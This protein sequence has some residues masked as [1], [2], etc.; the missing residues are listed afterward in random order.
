MGVRQPFLHQLTGIVAEMMKKPYPELTE[1]VDRVSQVIRG[2]EED[3]FSKI[4][5][6]LQR[7]ERVFSDMESKGIV[8]VPGTDAFDMYQTFG[9]PPELFETLAAERNF[10]FDRQGFEASMEEHGKVSGAGQRVE[11]FK[12]GPLDALK[13]VMHGTKFLGYEVTESPAVVKGIIAQDKLCETLTEVGHAAAVAI[14]LDQSPFYGESGGQVG[15]T[16]ELIGDGIRFEVTDTQ[17]NGEFILHMGHLRQGSLKLGASLTARVDAS[18]R[19]GI[20][21]AHSATHILH[22]ALQKYVGSHALQR[23]SKVDRDWLRFDFTNNGAVDRE[24][25]AKIEAEVNERIIAADSVSWQV[26]P[27]AEARK[28]GAMMLFGEKYPDMVR[29]VTMGDFSRELCGGTHLT[30]TGQVGLFKILAEEGISTGTRRITAATGLGAL[31]RVRQHEQALTEIAGA[32]KAPIAEAPARVAALAKEVRELKKQLTTAAASGEVSPE[33][34]LEGAVK[35]GDATFVVA[36]AAGAD[37]NVMRQLIDQLRR[38]AS[39]IAVLLASSA[40]GKVT[41]VAGISRELEAQ[42]LHAGNWVGETAQLV[43]GKGG[44][45]SD[46]AQAG[47]KEPAKLPAALESAKASIKKQLTGK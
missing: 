4:D 40:E 6:G 23:G 26:T 47:G 36:E 38:K 13:K 25:L 31:E 1:S 34:L 8:M 30:N 2:E 11:L 41:L 43:G 5:A 37:A 35:V 14:V 21:R 33:K 28:A 45:K 22:H 19:Q 42:G 44:G 18:R 15:D 32:L 7:I 12:T 46:M 17:R 16:G 27:I 29:M 24:T 10:S 39:P 3:F 20:R 9:F